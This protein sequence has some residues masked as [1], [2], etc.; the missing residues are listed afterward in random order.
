MMIETFYGMHRMPFTTEDATSPIFHT[1]TWPYPAKHQAG[2]HALLRLNLWSH[3]EI[4]TG[5]SLLDRFSPVYGW[6]GPV[7]V[8]SADPG[9]VRPRLCSEADHCRAAQCI[10]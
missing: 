4:E 5:Q 6:Q 9:S 2:L 1:P 8:P 3:R 10:H 7:R